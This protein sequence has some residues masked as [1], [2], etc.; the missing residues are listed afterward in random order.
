VEADRDL[1][2]GL[3]DIEDML[4]F[5]QP[6]RVAEDASEQPDVIPQRRVLLRGVGWGW[7]FHAASAPFGNA[8]VSCGRASMLRLRTPQRQCSIDGPEIEPPP[9]PAS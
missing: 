5:M 7:R 3:D 1:A 4:A 8:R 6:D 9:S 2:D